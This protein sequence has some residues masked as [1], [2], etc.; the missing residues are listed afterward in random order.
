MATIAKIIKMRHDEK[1]GEV[2]TGALV[3]GV[4]ST[5]LWGKVMFEDRS[6]GKVCRYLGKAPPIEAARVR[7]YLVCH[8]NILEDSMD[9]GQFTKTVVATR[10][11]E[12]EVRIRR[13][14]ETFIRI[15]D[16]VL[17]ETVIGV[18]LLRCN[19]FQGITWAHK[20]V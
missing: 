12:Q 8:R 5:G 2:G 11:E 20:R 4:G 18:L 19:C 16:F 14:L 17:S 7:R 13:A 1:N 9:K 10:P 15:S 3:V 6:L